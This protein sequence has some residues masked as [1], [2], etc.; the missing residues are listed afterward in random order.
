MRKYDI[1]LS[2]YMYTYTYVYVYVPIYMC[3]YMYI[4]ICI[5]NIYIYSEVKI[6]LII[7]DKE[8]M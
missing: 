7:A 6:A 1:Y 4:Y 2:E 5:Y 3:I 8:I